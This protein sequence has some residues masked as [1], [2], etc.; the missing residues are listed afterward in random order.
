MEDS[1][2][3]RLLKQRLCTASPRYPGIFTFANFRESLLEYHSLMR[4]SCNS[5]ASNVSSSEAHDRV[6]WHMKEGTEFDPIA[7]VAT[8]TGPARNLL[9][10]ERVA[11]NTL[12]RCS[13][14]ATKYILYLHAYKGL[15]ECCG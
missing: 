7:K 9:L 13:G 6:E 5:G 12:A 2:S 14:I 8:V 15:G 10:G 3:E 4:C 1:L 11:L